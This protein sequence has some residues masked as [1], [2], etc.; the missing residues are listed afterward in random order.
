ME[1]IIGI[2]QYAASA[3]TKF[4]MQKFEACADAI[5]KNS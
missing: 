2:Y 3:T 5:E 1:S 4:D